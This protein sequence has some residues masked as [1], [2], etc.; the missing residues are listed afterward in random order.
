MTVYIR[1]WNCTDAQNLHANLYSNLVVLISLDVKQ[2]IERGRTYDINVGTDDVRD[3]FIRVPR[4]VTTGLNSC[5]ILF[6]VDLGPVR[7]VSSLT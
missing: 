4:F 2:L 6:G 3:W 1:T 5:F 7:D